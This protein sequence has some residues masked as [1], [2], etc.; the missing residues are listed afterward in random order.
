VFDL[1]DCLSISKRLTE[2]CLAPLTG[3]DSETYL[4]IILTVVNTQQDESFYALRTIQGPVRDTDFYASPACSMRH[5]ACL[6]ALRQEI[7][8]VF[9]Y[10][11]PFRLPLCPTNDYS[12]VEP[13]DDFVWTNRILVWTAD[14]LKFCFGTERHSS[15]NNHPDRFEHWD[16]LKK[17]EDTW[18]E[19]RPPSFKPAFFRDS[20]P[21]Q[22]RIF[23]EFWHLN[24]CQLL[25]LQHYEL[26]FILLAVY[27]PRLPRVGLGSSAFQRTLERQIRE[28][29]LR[30]CGLALSNP[31]WITLLIT[32]AVGIAMFGEYFEEKAEQEA[33]IKMMNTLESEHAWPTQAAVDAL[34]EAWSQR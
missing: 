14:V 21:S 26:T 13:A 2:Q 27:D 16:S 19:M 25:G 4:N 29:T 12:N 17:F 5:S 8:S 23:P 34:R 32:A 15:T 3:W 6:N 28:A 10:R 7:W 22:G 24:E 20:D 18:R 33:L 11:R 31:K 9:L 30:L 1:H